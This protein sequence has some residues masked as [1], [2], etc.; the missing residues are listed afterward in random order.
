MLK[1][2]KVGVG[3]GGRGPNPPQYKIKFNN[4][5][6]RTN[7]STT[8]VISPG[9]P[10]KGDEE[11]QG[12]EEGD[13]EEEEE[14]REEEQQTGEGFKVGADRRKRRGRMTSLILFIYLF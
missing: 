4:K 10:H 9:R 5:I 2:G 1:G 13:D 11:E 12:M 7:Q 8:H 6:A 3:W 14:G